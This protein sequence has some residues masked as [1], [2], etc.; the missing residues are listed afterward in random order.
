M[1]REWTTV[2]FLLILST[3]LVNGGAAP[4]CDPSQCQL[5]D[6][7]CSSTDIPGLLSPADTPQFVVLTFDDAVTVSNIDFYRRAFTGRLNANQCPVSATFFVSHEY[8]NYQLVHELYANGHEIALH[9]I[10]HNATT[11]YWR[12]ASVQTLSEE[13]GGEREMV[14]H[15]ANIPK[16]DIRGIRLPFLQLSGEASFEMMTEQ[17]LTYDYSWPTIHH[18]AP[19]MWPYSLDYATRQDCVIGPCPVDSY[20][21]VWVMPMISWTDEANIF[22]SMVDT[23]V[24]MW[25]F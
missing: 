9:S 7:R 2:V 4:N 5:P 12:A 18:R 11:D 13:F 23:C 22:C 24:N 17:G 6:C 15:F 10:S 20:D 14:A 21:N 25:V 1:N 8:T 3:V 16:E 19:G